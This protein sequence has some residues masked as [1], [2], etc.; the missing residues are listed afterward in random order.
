M[1]RTMCMA[2]V[3]CMATRF[4][5]AS[6]HWPDKLDHDIAQLPE[7]VVGRLGGMSLLPLSDGRRGRKDGYGNTMKDEPQPVTVHM[8]DTSIDNGHASSNR[9]ERHNGETSRGA[10][11]ASADSTPASYGCLC[12]MGCAAI[13]SGPTGGWPGRPPPRRRTSQCRGPKGCSP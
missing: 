10:R 8:P 1:T 11:R 5:L 7:K 13:S 4:I 9:H 2:G 6:D 12:R 3:A